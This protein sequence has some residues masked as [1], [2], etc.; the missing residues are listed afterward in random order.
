MTSEMLDQ[1]EFLGEPAKIFICSTPRSGSYMLCR[2]MINAGLGV[3]HEYFNPLYMRQIAPRLGL[4]QSVEG[5]KWRPRNLRDRLPFRTG[6]RVAETD[7]LSK[8]LSGL[9]PRRCQRGIFAAKI[10]F[11]QYIKV[12]DNPVGRK[13]FDGG[14]FIY[15]FRE[16][17]LRQAVSRNIAYLTGRWGLD[18]TA[19]TPPSP[20]SDL[21]DIG[22]IDRELETLADEDRG[23]RVFLAKNGLSP[24]T[25]S[26]EQLCNDARGFIAVIARRLGID[27]DSLQQGYSEPITSSAENDPALPSRSELI[28][29]YLAA[30]RQ[31]RGAATARERLAEAPI[32]AAARAT[33]E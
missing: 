8:Y 26:Y 28:D 14:V 13:L 3:P 10:H 20:Q 7:F 30:V 33:V 6:D 31:V 22:G 29:R 19:S 9:I 4:A 23:W 11:D 16:D 12:L 32:G 24:L 1:P 15:L 5:L 25:V 2:Y 21:L 17:L 18:D 27:P